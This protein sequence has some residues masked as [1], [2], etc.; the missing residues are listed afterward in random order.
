MSLILNYLLTFADGPQERMTLSIET[1]Y[2]EESE[3]VH[4]KHI[5]H[6]LSDRDRPNMNFFRESVEVRGYRT[7]VSIWLYR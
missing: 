3:C 5:M 7:Y 6:M 2:F 4:S 1:F